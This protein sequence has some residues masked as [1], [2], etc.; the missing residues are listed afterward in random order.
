MKVITMFNLTDAHDKEGDRGIDEDGDDGVAR[1]RGPDPIAWW[2]C[3]L[4][5]LMLGCLGGIEDDV[6]GRALLW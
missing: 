3:I 4:L 5:L 6:G 1:G 2:R